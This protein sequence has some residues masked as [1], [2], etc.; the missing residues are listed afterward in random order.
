MRT[1]ALFGLPLNRVHSAVMHNAAFEAAGIDGRYQLEE[2]TAAELPG[3]VARAREEGWYGFQI[4]APHK[5]AIV[6]LLDEVEP[7]AAAIGAV[8]SVEVTPDGRL[9]GFNTDVLGFLAGLATV[10]ERPVEGARVVVA[11]AGGVAHAVAYGLATQH[12]AA[13]TVADLRLADSERLATEFADIVDTAEIDATTFD[14]P[15]LGE[16]LA[17]ADLFVNA[18]SVGMLSPGPVVAVESLA[19]EC[20]VFDVVYLP[21]TTELVRQA[22]ASG[23]PA[24]NGEGMLIAQAATAFV[25]WTG[26]A[27]PTDVMRTA[28]EPFLADPDA[29]P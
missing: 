26:A 18:T 11:G 10:L 20:A 2:V 23:R 9:V 28:V 24:A 7:A 5:Q 8:N 16:T 14:D 25:R 15:G 1:A 17:A 4:T 13:M 6:P 22:R 19:P 12:P 21:R 29:R 27:D 3:Q